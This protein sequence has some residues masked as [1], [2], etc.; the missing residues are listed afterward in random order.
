MGNTPGHVRSRGPET[1]E[2]EE[3]GIRKMGKS[4]KS[5]AVGSLS[6]VPRPRPINNCPFQTATI[7]AMEIGDDNGNGDDEI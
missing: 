4:D 6:G 5:F 3:L 1:K 7:G 2:N